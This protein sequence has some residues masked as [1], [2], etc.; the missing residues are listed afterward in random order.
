MLNRTSTAP[1]RPEN[2]VANMTLKL[3]FQ[4]RL[5]ARPRGDA[6]TTKPNFDFGP[7]SR[8]EMRRIVA[9]MIG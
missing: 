5:S 4:A 1:G 6:K 2:A 3:R 9:E 7:I 8:S